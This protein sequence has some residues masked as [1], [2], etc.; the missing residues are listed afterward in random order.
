MVQCSRR[1][2]PATTAT[3]TRPVSRARNG[4]AAAPSTQGLLTR[5]R[6]LRSEHTD[7]TRECHAIAHKWRRAGLCIWGSRCRHINFTRQLQDW[8]FLSLRLQPRPPSGSGLYFAS[9][10]FAHCSYSS[11]VRSSDSFVIGMRTGGG[12]PVCTQGRRP[13][14]GNHGSATTCRHLS[15]DQPAIAYKWQRN[16]RRDQ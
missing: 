10:C 3:I 13:L 8:A 12:I 6:M 15:L 1:T 16:G 14:A 2:R 11:A 5:R 4:S 9:T 7:M